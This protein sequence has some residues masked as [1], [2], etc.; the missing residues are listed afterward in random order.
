MRRALALLAL[1]APL[2]ARLMVDTYAGGVI[3]SG[4][5]AQNV[6]LGSISGI[7]WDASGNIVICDTGNNVI[8]RI[9]TNG[10][11][12]TIV[13][14]GV[15]GYGG[16]GGPA[17]GALIH[18]PYSP[19][20]DP[21]GNLYFLDSNNFRIRRV[22]TKGVIT[23]IAG[24]GEA[25]AAGL[26]TSGPA[27]SRALAISNFIAVDAS[28]RVYYGGNNSVSLIAG[29]N[30]EVVAQ[31]AEPSS[32][33]IDAS[34]N[35]Y[36]A[37]AAS[38]VSIYRISPAGAVS[39]FVSLPANA[40]NYAE[41]FSADAAGSVYALVDGQFLRYA[42]DGSS[43]VLPAPA[44][45][46]TLH[47]AVDAQ[48][49]VAFASNYAP[50]VVQTFSNRS[51]QTTVAGANPLPAPDGT[52]LGSAWFLNPTSIA[53]SHTGD[54]YIAESGACQI[55]KINSAGALST[56]A[57]TGSCNDPQTANSVY[58]T[59][60]ALDSQNRV[61]VIDYVLGFYSIAQDGTRSAVIRTP[62][63]GGSQQLAV[64]AK[65]RVFVLGGLSLY[66][67]FSDLT[68]QGI[69]V[70]P[71]SAG[72]GGPG[73][74][75]GLGTDAGGHVYFSAIL[76]PPA[77]PSPI[78]YRVNDDLTFTAKYP[79]F[80]PS[81]IAFDPSGNIW[82]VGGGQIMGFGS[83]GTSY[84]GLTPGFSGDGGPLQSAR[85]ST[86]QSI[87]FGPDGNLYFIDNGVRIRRMSGSGPAAAP[88]ISQGGIVNGANYASG[89]IAPGEIISIFGSNFGVSSLQVSTPQ[90][91][92][93]PAILGRTRVWF[94]LGGP[95]GVL[96]RGNIAAVTPNQ[97]N[98]FVPFEAGS[99]TPVYVQ[100]QVDQVLSNAVPVAVTAI[101]P[102][103]SPSILNQDGTLNSAS[104]PAPRGSIV[105]LYG[106]GLGAMNPQLSDGYLAISTPFSV[107]VIAPTASVGGQTATVYYAGDAP[108][109]ATGIF[110]M[111]VGIPTTINAGASQVQVSSNGLSSQVPIYVK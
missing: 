92:T 75:S 55:R 41:L 16:E 69:I 22:D 23:T 13:G 105:S 93:V 15:T 101:A 52:P 78:T 11:I 8:R 46:A 7:T 45:P 18:T 44:N 14:T 87:A 17:T 94:I 43:T 35:V 36:V 20:Y 85:M 48:G 32:L 79:N 90:N 57:G 9:D 37:S 88:V 4:V 21:A 28:G 50:Y 40:P 19:V 91:N 33:A 24:D 109:F 98:V 83:Q 96:V 56:F 77:N 108:F 65:D 66:C 95:D 62:V 84:V 1:L 61:W 107:P 89:S 99:E 58:P 74:L 106:T 68:Y 31:I 59:S 80:Y 3:R 2:Q 72:G 73:T 67:V 76:N 10:T 54:L 103:V 5:P 26:D 64:D 81:A 104:N 60:I 25:F 39:T 51:V 29:G 53:F 71:S 49:N 6:A 63:A 82:G 27:T 110:Q 38:P 86:F 42:P 47:M 97:I 34:G 12:E 70:P 111:N 30:I 100:V 102:G